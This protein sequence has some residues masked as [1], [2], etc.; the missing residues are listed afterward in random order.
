MKVSIYS[1]P[2]CTYCD[3][4]KALFNEHKIKYTEYN[5]KADW[6]KRKE[7]VEKSGQMSVPVIIVDEE[8]FIGFDRYTLGEKLGLKSSWEK[9]KR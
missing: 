6:D 2:T 3:K 4:A 8:V 7:M 9:Q 1:T 5:V